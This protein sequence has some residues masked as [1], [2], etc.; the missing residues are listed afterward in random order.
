MDLGLRGCCSCRIRKEQILYRA[1]AVTPTPL[2]ITGED[3]FTT[4]HEKEKVELKKKRPFGKQFSTNYSNLR[5]LIYKL[6][7]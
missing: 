4:L 5:F 2:P 6:H 1:V 7:Y 3:V